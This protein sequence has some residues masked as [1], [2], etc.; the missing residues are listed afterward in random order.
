MCKDT[1]HIVSNKNGSLL[2]GSHADISKILLYSFACRCLNPEIFKGKT[3]QTPC[4]KNKAVIYRQVK[5]MN[6][7]NPE[8]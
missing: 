8:E 7:K 1:K 6:V 5:I 4:F 2:K 3:S